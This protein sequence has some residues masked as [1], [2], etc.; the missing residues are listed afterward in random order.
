MMQI[1]DNPEPALLERLSLEIR[2]FNRAHWPAIARKPLAVS[3]AG[4]QG[5]LLG[6]IDGN[7]FGNWLFIEHLWVN[8]AQRGQGTGSKLLAAMETAARQRGCTKAFLDTL[9]FQARPFYERHG[10]V[11]AFTLDHY[12]LD[13]ARHYLTKDL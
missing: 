5:E 9:D 13:G 7:T 6:G 8:P 10:Y 3:L 4:D 1:H 12:P 2:S 11:L